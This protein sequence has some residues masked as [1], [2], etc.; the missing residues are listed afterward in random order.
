MDYTCNNINCLCSL[1]FFPDL[2]LRNFSW[3][4][5]FGHYDGCF[6]FR[7]K[8]AGSWKDVDWIRRYLMIAQA[9]LNWSSSWTKP[10]LRGRFGTCFMSLRLQNGNG[11]GEGSPGEPHHL[12]ACVHLWARH[13]T[14]PYPDITELLSWFLAFLSIQFQ[15]WFINGICIFILP[16]K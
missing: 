4:G 12:K 13:L 15:F 10:P 16:L 2:C 8:G 9:D 3:Y 7:W 11:V 14:N 1:D 6:Y 5:S